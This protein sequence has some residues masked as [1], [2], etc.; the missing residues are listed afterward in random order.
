V[1]G[2]VSGARRLDPRF[3]QRGLEKISPVLHLL[4]Q[5]GEN[6]NRTPAQVALNWLIAQGVLPIPGAKSATQAQQ[7]AGALGWSMRREELTQ[8]DLLTRSWQ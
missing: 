6:Y 3:T 1:K 4:A 8:L 5:I 2:Q 7:N